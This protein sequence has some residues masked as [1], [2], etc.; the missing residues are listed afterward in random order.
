[1]K[2]LI[3][4]GSATGM[5]VAAKLKR[6]DEKH[7]IIVIQDKEYVSLGACGIPYFVRH[8][9]DKPETLIARKVEK[10]EETGVKVLTKATVRQIDFNNKLVSFENQSIKYDNLV[11][12]VGAKFITRL[13]KILM[14]II[15][16]QSIQ[17]KMQLLLEIQ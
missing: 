15:Y 14:L 5:G 6:L 3:I 16:L 11:I 7:E 12:A 17:K 8:N 9:F 1:M 13:L 2:T 4:D 10:F